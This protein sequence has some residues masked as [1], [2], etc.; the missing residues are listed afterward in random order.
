[1]QIRF[2]DAGGFVAAE[3]TV[4]PAEREQA[5]LHL[6]RTFRS[7]V[8]H[9][10]AN[11]LDRHPASDASS[12]YEGEKGSWPDGST[13]AGMAAAKFELAAR[14]WTVLDERKA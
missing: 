13:T 14:G 9:R 1:M 8:M 12:I 7:V 11:R 6:R 5:V 2:F 10:L 3:L 4:P